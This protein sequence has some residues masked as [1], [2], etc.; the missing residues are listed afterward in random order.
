DRRPARSQWCAARA[1]DIPATPS[2]SPRPATPNP[3]WFAS[4]PTPNCCRFRSSD[5]L[6][7]TRGK[8]SLGAAQSSSCYGKSTVALKET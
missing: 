6:P 4:T 2:T 5:R 3:G 8:P 7:S 1:T